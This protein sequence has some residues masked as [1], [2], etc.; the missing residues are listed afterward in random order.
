MNP[1]GPA[2]GRTRYDRSLLLLGAKRNEVL[3]LAEVLDYGI[4]SFGDRDYLKLYGMTPTH[5]YARGIRL[6]GRT[7]VECTRDDLGGHY[8]G[9]RM[10]YAVQVY[11]TLEPTSLAQ[12][13]A[14]FDWSRRRTYD[15]NATGGNHGLLLGTTGWRPL[16]SPA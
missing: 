10:I 4:D 3:T 2:A 6:L 14:M 5:W 16:L 9:H 8:A 13:Q 1:A 15:L 11:Q 7:A 12:V